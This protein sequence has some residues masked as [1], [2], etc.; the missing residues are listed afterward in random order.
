MIKKAREPNMFTFFVFLMFARMLFDTFV[1]FSYLF[2]SIGLWGLAVTMSFFASVIV[3]DYENQR[4]LQ[5]EKNE[6]SVLP[7]K[8][9]K[10]SKSA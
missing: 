3:A 4:T 8:D 2:L 5:L 1:N 9:L 6:K 7:E 10:G